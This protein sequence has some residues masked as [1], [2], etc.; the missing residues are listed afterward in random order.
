VTDD[1]KL[2]RAATREAELV[3]YLLDALEPEERAA[4]EARLAA[5]P[6][7]QR[8]ARAWTETLA[9]IG[10]ASA[11]LTSPSE[12]TRA[13]VL[14]EIRRELDVSATE[15]D[16]E[17]APLD[18]EITGDDLELEPDG[19]ES[20]S[21]SNL[22]NFL[23]IAAAVAALML[24]VAALWRMSIADQRLEAFRAERAAEQEQILQLLGET[25]ARVDGLDEQVG[26]IDSAVRTMSFP[27]RQS[28][29]LAGLES[30]PRASGVAHVRSD[31]QSAVFQ[32]FG[33]LPPLAPGTDL[34]ALV[35]PRRKSGLGR[36]LPG[37]RRWRRHRGGRGAAP[38]GR[39]RR[40]GGHRRA[41][42]R[43]A[44]THR[45]DG[46]AGLERSVPGPRLPLFPA[47]GPL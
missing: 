29:V 21:R 8:D 11:V 12:V 38:A 28:V 25:R 18:E 37:R 30:A 14:A 35:H 9:R 41:R 44:R 47:L 20:I 16:D 13:R 36:H 24:G 27:A 17:A 42:R 33:G 32:A 46:I 23:A 3:A 19:I 2:D 22:S 5:S 31:Q 39:D 34:P 15:K 1:R 4:V 26:R 43:R 40:L 45:R 6:V 10:E 7:A